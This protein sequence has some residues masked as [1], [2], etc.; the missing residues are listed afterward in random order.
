MRCI[1][2]TDS[3]T[4]RCSGF[5]VPAGR[6]EF[7]FDL[8]L[9]AVTCILVQ[10]SGVQNKRVVSLLLN[11]LGSHTQ[12]RLHQTRVAQHQ[13]IDRLLHARWRPP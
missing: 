11:L 9:V 8:P 4:P 10:A 13:L 12:G 7:P 2:D 1:F 3:E 5:G 6:N